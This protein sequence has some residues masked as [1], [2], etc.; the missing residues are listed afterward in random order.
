V[1]VRPFR[2]DGHIHRALTFVLSTVVPL[3]IKCDDADADGDGDGVVDDELL[4]RLAGADGPRLVS[5]LSLPLRDDDDDEE[6]E[7]EEG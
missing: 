2:H 6:D 1:L 5:L 4:A 7:V 3:A